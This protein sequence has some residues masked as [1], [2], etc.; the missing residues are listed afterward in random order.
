MRVSLCSWFV[1]LVSTGPLLAQDPDLVLRAPSGLGFGGSF[2]GSV[3]FDNLGTDSVDGWSYGLCHD[4]AIVELV[5]FV[6]SAL[7]S[8]VNGGGAPGFGSTLVVDPSLGG[9]QGIVVDLFGVNKLAPGVGCALADA[10]YDSQPAG[11]ASLSTVTICNSLGTP[12]VATVVVIG[13]ASLEPTRV[14]GAIRVT[15]G[16]P[17]SYL[18]G[19]CN[20]DAVY[21]IA[22]GVFLLNALFQGGLLPSCVEACDSNGEGVVDSSDAVYTF[23]YQ[24]AGGPPPPMPFPDCGVGEVTDDCASSSCP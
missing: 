17:R 3:V 23:T 19:D 13:G 4:G 22:D 21:D 14:A 10:T 2:T 16:D 9:T 20:N 24:F 11:L 1:I 12:P 6:D 7:V 15:F 18:R 8:T 5:D